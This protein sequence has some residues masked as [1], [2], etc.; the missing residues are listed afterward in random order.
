[1]KAYDP[2]SQQEFSRYGDATAN[3]ALP[4]L[5]AHRR[6]SSGEAGEASAALTKHYEL[7]HKEALGGAPS[8]SDEE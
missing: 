7:K 4:Y 6:L 8:A 3:N 2:L 5:P 1:M